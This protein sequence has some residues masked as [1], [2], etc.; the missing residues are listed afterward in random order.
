[1]GK[2][3]ILTLVMV[4]GALIC[5][6]GGVF[7]FNP[8]DVQKLNSTN[9]CNK[10]DLSQ[11]NLAGIDFYGAELSGANLSG[12]NLKGTLFNDADLKGANLKGASVDKETSF[13]G[14]KLSDAIWMDGT[15][16]KSGQIGRCK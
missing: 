9:K 3:V 10:C 8:Q 11:A 7:G 4:V 16:C 12:A 6:P 14:A 2:A 13:V 15:K 1:M 5:L